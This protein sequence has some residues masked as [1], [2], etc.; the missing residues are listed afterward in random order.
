MEHTRGPRQRLGRQPM[1]GG[2]SGAAD[3]L[4]GIL[5]DLAA[6]AEWLDTLLR[7]LA[8]ERWPPATPAVGWDIACQ[9]AHLASTDEAATAAVTDPVAWRCVLR[10]ASSAPDRAA[11]D[12]ARTGATASWPVLLSRW[13]TSRSALAAVLRD[14]PP[15][16]RIPWFGPPMSA[17]SMATA[18][19]M[20][21]WA[22]GIDMAD[23]LGTVPP[24]TDRVRHVALLGVLT[25]GF[26]FTARGLPVPQSPVRV[27]LTFPGGR[28]WTRGPV[29]ADQRAT[30][31]AHDFALPVT[32][33]GHRDDLGVSAV[34]AD[35]HRWL[36]IAQAYAGPPGSG[37]T[38]RTKHMGQG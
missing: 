1:T 3:R 7:D 20:E 18:R 35:A 29:D 34:G 19:L 33:R 2:V 26:S 38:A 21:R 36:D 23:G 37:R 30:G 5:A 16:S 22:H 11:D 25:H 15:D 8:P 13:R 24:R 32:R 10:A 27:E 14:A 28:L 9:V 4:S 12:A 17:A 6:E 31:P